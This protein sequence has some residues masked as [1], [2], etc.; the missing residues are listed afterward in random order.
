MS[1]DSSGSFRGASGTPDFRVREKL[2]EG[3]RATVFRIGGPEDE[4]QILTLCRGGD[5]DLYRCEEEGAIMAL[6][7]R[8]C[9]LV[10][11]GTVESEAPGGLLS[12]D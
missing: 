7:G 1:S 9:Q 11:P 5:A 4:T 10:P 8:E 2:Y 3:S 12:H 6:V